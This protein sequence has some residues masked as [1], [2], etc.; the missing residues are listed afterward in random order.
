MFGGASPFLL[1][2]TGQSRDGP[3]L[4]SPAPP[5]AGP[6]TRFN[7]FS[8]YTP[9]GVFGDQGAFDYGATFTPST[10]VQKYGIF[11]ASL[12]KTISR[13]SIKFGWD[14]ERTHVDGVEAN[15]QFDQLFAT[16]ADYLQFGP[17]DDGFF[18]LATT[19]GLTPQAN[20]IKLRNNY[21]A[22]WIQD[23]WKISHSLTIN[24]GV[25]W[26][27]DSA[28]DK[29]DNVSPRIGFAWSATPKTVVR[30][31]FGLFYD[32]FRLGL[33]RDIPG[34]GGADIRESQPLS[35]P[36]LFYGVPTIA[37]N[38]FS[39]CDST[40]MTDAQIAASEATCPFSGAFGNGSTLY[41][42]DHLNN[43]GITPIPAN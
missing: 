15:G 7:L 36:R 16:Q 21:N 14:F 43:I 3:T 37:P 6:P 23:D 12:A 2:I 33:V 31:S 1:S 22:L 19:G 42:I 28:F 13:H 18:L 25:R 32:H 29:K 10:M 26:D 17:I 8:S 35:F 4:S 27:Y 41:G 9:F 11:G 30:G 39:V 24:G 5:Q 38:L 34:F 20:Q 40:F